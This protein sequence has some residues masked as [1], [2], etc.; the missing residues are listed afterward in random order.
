[1]N[2]KES[3]LK[4]KEITGESLILARKLLPPPTQHTHTNTLV[5]S[6]HLFYRHSISVPEP[7][8]RRR[9]AGVLQKE[10]GRTPAFPAKLKSSTDKHVCG[11]FTGTGL[12]YI[13][14]YLTIALPE[15]RLSLKQQKRNGNLRKPQN[16]GLRL[17]R[18]M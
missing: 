7:F 15:R 17:S 9:P 12:T 8:V 5:I 18:K 2:V 3:S 14:L 6:H 13:R 4:L 11:T 16:Q 1:M 10:S